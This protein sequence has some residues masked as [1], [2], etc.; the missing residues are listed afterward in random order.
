MVKKMKQAE[1]AGSEARAAAGGQKLNSGLKKAKIRQLVFYVLML[2]FP[3]VQFCI[4]YIGVNANAILLAFKRFDKPDYVWNGFNTIVTAFR[5]LTRDNVMLQTGLNSLILYLVGL[6]VGIPLGLLFSYFIYKKIALSG[7]FRVL[8]FMPS[9]IS[10]IVMVTIFKYFVDNAIPGAYTAIMKLLT[11]KPDY[12]MDGLLSNVATRFGTIL[13][14]N[15]WIGFGV[16]ILM[17]SGA[18]NGI[19]GSIVES[20]RVEGV[21]NMQEFF[22]I[23]LPMIYPTIVTFVV[24]GV[25]GL[26]TNQMNLYHLYGG[27]SPQGVWT[28]GYYL[29]K[30]TDD[31]ERSHYPQISAMGLMMTAVALPLTLLVKRLMEKYGPS[32]D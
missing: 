26:F 22:Y 9:I 17:Y 24:V 32:V 7:M 2:A 5:Y 13:F 11:G 27:G 30:L 15:I 10:S 31:A 20:A 6:V 16:S 12:Q 23:S 14:Y 28:F 25:A 29:F 19:D 8:L 1:F 4:F 18:M 21:K 3:I